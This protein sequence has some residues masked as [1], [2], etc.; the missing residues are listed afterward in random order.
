M[1]FTAKIETDSID[2]YMKLNGKAKATKQRCPWC[3][4]QKVYV[5]MKQTGDITKNDGT[6]AKNEAYDVICS[7]CNMIHQRHSSEVEQKD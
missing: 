4:S 7:E 6:A 1:A 2:D 3:G 5:S